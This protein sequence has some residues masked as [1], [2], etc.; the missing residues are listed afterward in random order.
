MKVLLTAFKPFNN[1]TSNFSIDVL[2]KINNPDKI[3]LDV[4]YNKCYEDLT[5]E[6]N[7]DEFDFIIALG[8][9]RNRKE[10]MVELTAK[11]ICN[12]KIEDNNKNLLINT[13]I[14]ENEIDQL[15]TK[16]D[17]N[18]FKDL[19]SFSND[20]GTFVCNNLYYHLL[21]NYPTKSL[22]IHIPYSNNDDLIK[23]ALKIEQIIKLL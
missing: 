14:K 22:F 19:I 11:N 10:I 15:H 1:E 3:I 4:V 12:A 21:Y 17:T 9:A 13:P 20:A 18:K 8:E 2:N 5:S 6:F 23:H 7:L 16:V